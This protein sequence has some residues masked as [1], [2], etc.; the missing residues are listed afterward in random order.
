MVQGVASSLGD[1]HYQGEVPFLLLK[2]GEG[3]TGKRTQIWQCGYCR[4]SVAISCRNQG[5][6]F[7][8]HLSV[9]EC[10]EEGR[11]IK[12]GARLV[13]LP[14]QSPAV[15]VV[16]GA[17]DG[18][19]CQRALGHGGL[20]YDRVTVSDDAGGDLREQALF[21]S[22]VV[23]PGSGIMHE[24]VH[25]LNRAF[26]RGSYVVRSGT[27]Y[28]MRYGSRIQRGHLDAMRLPDGRWGGDSVTV[29]VCLSV[30][31]RSF[32]VMG[33]GGLEEVHLRLGD[34]AVLSAGC[35]HCGLVQEGAND[36]LFFYLDRHF[37]C[38]L[39]AARGTVGG[40]WDDLSASQQQGYSVSVKFVGGFR[41]LVVA[42][43]GAYRLEDPS[44]EARKRKKRV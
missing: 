40:L 13:E 35:Y 39:G 31:G 12:L 11:G 7:R 18:D 10:F 20:Q 43:R 34:M 4:G 21:S 22:S 29:F 19:L 41:G 9:K 8:K 42:L 3:A 28:F 36:V 5:R 33:A 2:W 15:Y 26:P 25:E 1:V 38:T 14:G 23:S 30:Q 6:S 27:G 24:A 37:E 44:G 17:V 16:R 32:G